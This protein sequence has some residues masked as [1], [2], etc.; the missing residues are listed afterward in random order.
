M[1]G[2]TSLSA[3]CRWS[4]CS[5]ACQP[6]G[7]VVLSDFS[8][9]LRHKLVKVPRCHCGRIEKP[10]RL[11]W[12]LSTVCFHADSLGLLIAFCNHLGR[13]AKS[14]QDDFASTPEAIAWTFQRSLQYDTVRVHVCPQH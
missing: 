3:F 6:I 13:R 12:H 11:R 4:T 2:L 7:T 14:E 5:G 1:F 8:S 10:L 9:D